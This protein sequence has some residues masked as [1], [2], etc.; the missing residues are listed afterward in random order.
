MNYNLFAKHLDRLMVLLRI[1]WQELN[2]ADDDYHL[3]GQLDCK[4]CW[5]KDNGEGINIYFGL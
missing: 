1:Y 2:S 3:N 4:Y 5:N